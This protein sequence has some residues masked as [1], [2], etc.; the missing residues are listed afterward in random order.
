MLEET[1]RVA[2]AGWDWDQEEHGLRGMCYD[3]INKHP[4]LSP[5][6]PDDLW[7]VF[8]E[9]LAEGGT[10]KIKYD[11]FKGWQVRGKRKSNGSAGEAR[12]TPK[13]SAT[14]KPSAA[15]A[16]VPRRTGAL[17]IDCAAEIEPEPVEWVWKGRIARGKHTAFAGEPGVSKSQAAINIAATISKG[18]LW[19]N[20]EGRAPI[21]KVI[22][23]S[24][25]DGAADTIVPRLMAADADRGQVHI[26]KA[27]AEHGKGPRTFNL[28]TDLGLLE[29]T[30]IELGDVQ[31]VVID[32]VSAY[33]GK[34]V[35]S[36]RDTEVRSVLAPVT[37]MSE[38]LGTAI[39]TIAHFNK[40]GN[41]GKALHKFMGSIAFVAGPRAAF[42]VM[43]DPDDPTCRLFL[44][45]KNNLSAPPPG[46]SFR[47]EQVVLP[48]K[49]IETSRIVWDFGTVD[50]TADEAVAASQAGATAP[51]LEEAKDL[52]ASL[53]GKNVK[54][55]EKAGK[56]AGISWATMRRAKEKLGFKSSKDGLNGGWLW[57]PR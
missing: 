1:R 42:A 57:E 4:D 36:H 7:T 47:I 53:K 23:L 10:P 11:R 14:T 44:H 2:P 29:T 30:I 26:I 37:E 55:I 3:W 28:Q 54:E 35:D 38:R 31:L 17:V 27:V 5:A 48:V 52:V 40:S 43:E 16:P 49:G 19:P 41:S 25:E 34:G 21:G 33:F 39:L 18:G 12:E 15:K 22:F 9:V 13:P 8:E 20:N 51:T 56:D 50:M 6:L 45:A 46:L 32:P 24:A